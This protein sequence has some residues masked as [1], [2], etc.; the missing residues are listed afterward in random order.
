MTTAA[1][2]DLD[3]IL[4]ISRSPYGCLNKF[5]CFLEVLQM[6]TDV[7]TLGQNTCLEPQGQLSNGLV[8]VRT[9]KQLFKV[10]EPVIQGGFPR[11]GTRMLNLDWPK[12]KHNN[13]AEGPDLWWGPAPLSS[14]CLV[15]PR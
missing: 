1:A 7:S 15:A 13:G 8:D 9:M 12:I 5:G 3:E 11:H 14:P 10:L 6:L 4:E 2:S